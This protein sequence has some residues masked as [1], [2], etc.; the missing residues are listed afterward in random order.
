MDVQD[1]HLT[2][3]QKLS[4]LD[5]TARLQQ[6]LDARAQD[7]DWP[8]LI[9]WCEQHVAHFT[10]S[11]WISLL[12]HMSNTCLPGQAWKSITAISGP[13]RSESP[14]WK[15]YQDQFHRQW[16]AAMVKNMGILA[17]DQLDDALW[18]LEFFAESSKYN[19]RPFAE[20]QSLIAS[21]A[22]AQLEPR[23]ATMSSDVHLMLVDVAVLH[24]H[25]LLP[26]LA[27]SAPL[28]N[29]Y[30][31]PPGPITQNHVSHIMRAAV[32]SKVSEANFAL[33]HQFLP[34]PFQAEVKRFVSSVARKKS[35]SSIEAKVL[36]HMAPFLDAKA[37]DKILARVKIH[38]PI[39]SSLASARAITQDPVIAAALKKSDAN[40]RK[41]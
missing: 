35:L 41:M 6:Q 20:V 22:W 13:Y 12:T 36:D 31:N 5:A 32:M 28:L 23:I 17:D 30:N 2:H 40:K 25:S 27:Q 24:D 26:R 1:D 9:A 29:V 3:M 11:V 8:Q 38:L 16:A 7:Q 19:N 37:Q 15:N 39:M 33:L 34:T 21:P 10:P 18:C 14:A 4:L